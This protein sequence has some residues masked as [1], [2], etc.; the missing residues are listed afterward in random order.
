MS[1]RAAQGMQKKKI[2]PALA[3]D[4]FFISIIIDL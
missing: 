1:R 4:E 2:R 3:W